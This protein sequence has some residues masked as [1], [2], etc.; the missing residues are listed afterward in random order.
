M[1]TT[2]E[3]APK[4]WFP[5]VREQPDAAFQLFCFP[6]A[7]G[8]ASAYIRWRQLLAPSVELWPVE[9]PAHETRLRDSP[10]GSSIELATQIAR[11]IAAVVDR[12]FALFGHSMGALLAFEVKRVLARDHGLRPGM[13]F[14][15]GY[16]APHLAPH[17]P[18]IRHLPEAAFRDELR[19]YGGT[20]EEILTDE[21]FMAFLSPLLRHDLGL[22]ETHAHAAGDA[23][24]CPIVAFGGYHDLTVPWDRLLSWSELTTGGFCAHFLPGGHFF[25]NACAAEVTRLV[26]RHLAA[27]QQVQSP[28]QADEVHLWMADIDQPPPVMEALR[29]DLPEAEAARSATYVREPDRARS[30]VARGVLRNLLQDYVG[31]P[32]RS[33][34]VTTS[35]TG[36]PACE[37]AK[38]IEFN[39]SHSGGKVLLGFTAA[40]SVGVDVEH[41]REDVFSQQL[42]DQIASGTELEQLNA[43]GPARRGAAFFDLWVRKEAWLKRT[44]EGFT[45]SPKML[46][47]GV[48]PVLAPAGAK[49]FDDGRLVSF[50]LAQGYAAAF[51]TQRPA[52]LVTLRTWRSHQA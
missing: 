35:S 46:Q 50:T 51:A 45:G 9:Y 27:G 32:G 49:L 18:P 36:K 11:Q 34:S 25:I 14:V 28:P 38:P 13:L 3:S 1:R 19:V 5:S 20:P 30:V 15:S 24:R 7:G 16:S 42:A 43:I 2:V 8:G 12:P 31:I 17:R 29:R 37:A 6:F 40:Q 4:V 33:L 10:V 48:S 23:L 26:H 21:R 39:V 44:G 41:V 47:V 52:K 22:C